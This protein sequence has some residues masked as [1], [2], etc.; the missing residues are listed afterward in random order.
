MMKARGEE[1]RMPSLQIRNLPPDVYEALA[2]RAKLENRSLAQQAIA[3]LRKMSGEERRE[4]RRM[5][6]EKIALELKE[7]GPRK[8]PFSPEEAIREDRSR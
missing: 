6:L 1:N 2:F 7:H 4:R 3:D 8:L 5:V